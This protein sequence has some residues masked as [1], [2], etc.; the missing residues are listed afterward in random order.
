MALR[1]LAEQRADAARELSG[2][3]DFSL[4]GVRDKVSEMLGLIGRSNVFATYTKH[5]ISHIDHM[6]EMLEWVIPEATQEAM[7]PADWLMVVLAIYFHDLGMLVTQDEFDQRTENSHFMSWF[8]SLDKTTEGQ[9]YLARTYRMSEAEKESFFFQEWV[10]HGHASR[11]YEWI[12]GQESTRWS[13]GAED[14]SK[15][16]GE[17]VAPLPPRF[18]DHLGTVC[19]SH[20]DSNLDRT[21]L[22]PLFEPCGGSYETAVNVQYAAILLR[23]VDL[24]H[25]TADRAPSVA[26]QLM[27][28]TDPKGVSEW[29]KQ[30]GTF[31]V[32][33]RDRVLDDDPNSAWVVVRADFSEEQPL[34]ALQEYISYAT[35]QINQSRRW[36]AKSQEDKNAAKYEFPW[37]GLQG[38]VRLNGVRPIPLK[39]ELDRGRLLDLLVGHTI[40]NDATVAL[41]EL[42]QN[43]IDAVR[44]Y[45]FKHRR[46][47][48]Q[49]DAKANQGRVRVRWNEANRRLIV[50][51][52]GTG[53]DRD[54]IEN[55][56]MMV[57]ASYYSTEQFKNEFS[58]FSPISRFGI[59]VLTCFMISDDIEILT[60]QGGKG[61]RV[62]MTSVHSDYLL[63]ELG[64]DDP[65]LAGL[66]AH[67]TR[68]SLRLR[69][70]IDLQKRSVRDIVFHWVVLPEC[71]VEYLEEGDE[72]SERD[73]ERV[74]YASVQ[75]ALEEF[76]RDELQKRHSKKKSWWE[77]EL[78]F[79]YKRRE[80]EDDIQSASSPGGSVE[81]GFAVRR[82][83]GRGRSLED[84]VEGLPL[85]CI[86]GIRAS[87][88]VPWYGDSIGSIVSVRGNRQLR[89]TVSRADLEQDKE[90]ERL[91]ALVSDCL[92]EHVID[93]VQQT[94]EGE[95]GQGSLS[96]A[97]SAA[98]W[99]TKDLV[100]KADGVEAR[101]Y[102]NQSIRQVPMLVIE[103]V[104][105]QDDGSRLPKR[106]L[107][108]P[109]ELEA[110][111][112][113]WTVESRLVDSL[114]IVSRDLGRE[115]S[116][117][118]FLLTLAPERRELHLSPL[119]ADA[120]HF[121]DHLLRTHEMTL[122]RIHAETRQTAILWSTHLEGPRE[123]I[124]ISEERFV[125][126]IEADS[127][128]SDCLQDLTIRRL[129]G[130]RYVSA[131]YDLAFWSGHVEVDR[132]VEAFASLE[133]T[134]VVP[135]EVSEPQLEAV[136]T[137]VGV[138]YKEGG[139]VAEVHERLL[140]LLRTVISSS[141]SEGYAVA[142]NL[143]VCLAALVSRCFPDQYFS[144][145]QVEA[146]DLFVQNSSRIW[147]Q[148]IEEL[149]RLQS[150]LIDQD[151][152]SNLDWVESNR[153][154]FE[155]QKYWIDWFS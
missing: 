140:R 8:Q 4:V 147:G 1:T 152:P 108:S 19:K 6:L 25:I 88:A 145:S 128:V 133:R 137:R 49:A 82:S 139:R 60:V 117:H 71:R 116:L 23:T 37:R 121:G 76:Y 77:A 115:V 132:V 68:V 123:E 26:F 58:E 64:A 36:A 127:Q 54:I 97:S 17:A 154:V 45:E 148:R 46:G 42:L 138:A 135:F 48:G 100:D 38:D 113:F 129:A 33:Q 10:R 83:W 66:G 79:A 34:F 134:A 56:L 94:V 110:L 125:Q 111:Q 5:D 28:I 9:E 144:R 142:A 63:R 87:G 146:V 130:G 112:E 141:S 155:A 102:V 50:E 101:E 15:L 75:E 22:F 14:V 70:S 52:N 2:F 30:R 124:L 62:K 96:Q 93:E 40:Y 57:G 114:G 143:Y 20:H 74:G 99:H 106:R 86:E 73:A 55:H 89:T 103:S 3:R 72:A 120:H 13:K 84:R 126:L 131:T 39:F 31:S 149:H 85:V 151:F 7:T 107:I 105:A 92:V 43:G 122:V 81:V 61:Y 16:V 21:D 29:D 44:F 136:G 78:E 118:E 51:D 95:K 109:E 150:G 12:T 59:G 32:L 65:L 18:R 41:R 90:Y 119:F 47:L 35:D 69:N 153:V 27:R 67:G 104:E 53:M 98:R 91:G 11:V 24:L 80:V